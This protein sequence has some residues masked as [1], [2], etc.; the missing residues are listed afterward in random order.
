MIWA[1]DLSKLRLDFR[2]FWDVFSGL[3]FWDFEDHQDVNFAFVDATQNFRMSMAEESL[4]HIC[5]S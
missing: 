5:T 4:W 1:L 3:E 2:I